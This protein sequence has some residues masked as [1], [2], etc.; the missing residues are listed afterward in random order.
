[1]TDKLCI[2]IVDLRIQ[3]GASSIDAESALMRIASSSMADEP[4]CLKFEVIKL[5][6]TDQFILYEIYSDSQA[7][8]DHLKTP[9]FLEFQELSENLFC[10]P[11]IRFGNLLQSETA[12]S[13]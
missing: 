7:F 11:I 1:M 10:K 9:H 6:E 13:N 12:N 5:K 8:S 4:S 2:V 3:E